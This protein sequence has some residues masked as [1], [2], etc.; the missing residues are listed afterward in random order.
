MVEGD[1]DRMEHLSDLR[2]GERKGIVDYLSMC[3]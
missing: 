2:N 3:I 1:G